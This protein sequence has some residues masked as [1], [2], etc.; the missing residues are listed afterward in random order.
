QRGPPGR[1]ARWAA[2]ASRRAAPPG[3]S[4]SRRR[5]LGAEAAAEVDLLE[6]R[7]VAGIGRLGD[8]LVVGARVGL[9]DARH[10]LLAAGLLVGHLAGRIAGDALEL[11][12]DRGDVVEGLGADLPLH[13]VVL[14]H[15]PVGA[16]R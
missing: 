6:A 4:L 7:G 1:R 10:Q 8:V 5:S 2:G 15:E 9:D 12:L 13:A 14:E 16:T 3:T 11:L